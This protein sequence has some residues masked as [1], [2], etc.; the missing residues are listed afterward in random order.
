MK[1]I[2]LAILVSLFTF[3]AFAQSAFTDD[4]K[5]NKGDG[6]KAIYFS[7]TLDGT[8]TLYSSSFKLYDCESVFSLWSYHGDNADSVKIKVLRQQSVFGTWD[9]A[10]VVYAADSLLTLRSI[11][12]T[13]S[14]SPV[15]SRYVFMGVKA[16]APS[17]TDNGYIRTF[18]YIIRAPLK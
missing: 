15:Y 14:N 9:S 8:D 12:D 5:E 7:G 1:T 11:G 4:A 3:T 17:I 16:G 6:V 2:F 13:I 10:K 18:K